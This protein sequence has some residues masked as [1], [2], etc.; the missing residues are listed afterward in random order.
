MTSIL[1]LGL[2]TGSSSAAAKAVSV[3]SDMSF[4]QVLAN[5]SKAAGKTAE[6]KFLDFAGKSSAEKMR[7]M[8][9][10]SLGVTEEELAAMPPDERLKIEQQIKE[11]MEQKMKENAQKQTGIIFAG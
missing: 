5:E 3:T 1:A 4:G 11:L 8:M 6:E 10:A 9:L 2:N 7:T